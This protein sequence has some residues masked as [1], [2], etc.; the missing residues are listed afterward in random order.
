MPTLYINVWIGYHIRNRF[1][2]HLDY[3]QHYPD[4]D[5]NFGANIC[6]GKFFPPFLVDDG[7]DE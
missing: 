2:T 6:A 1:F 5:A 4:L 7:P 3:D